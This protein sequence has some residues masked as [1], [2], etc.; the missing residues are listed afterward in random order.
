MNLQIKALK[1]LIKNLE[2][3]KEKLLRDMA[4]S[5]NRFLNATDY[6]VNRYNKEIM[7]YQLKLKIEEMKLN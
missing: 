5:G 6:L 2:D 1:L 3:K 7:K 4:K